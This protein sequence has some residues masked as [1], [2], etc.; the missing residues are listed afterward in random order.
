[1]HVKGGRTVTRRKRRTNFTRK[2]KKKG[3]SKD[4]EKRDITDEYLTSVY[5]DSKGGGAFGGVQNLLDQIHRET[6]VKISRK[7]VEEFL[8]S[9]DEY[10]LHRPA[11]KKFKTEK[12]IVGA[13][14]DYHQM[15]IMVFKAYANQNYGYTYILTVIDCLVDLRGMYQ[16]VR[17]HQRSCNS[18]C[19][20]ISK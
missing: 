14:N 6:R 1:M 13:I 11:V 4:N 16:Y 20:N 15:D 12:V 17:N 8:K 18:T 19:Q 9:R 2:K 7:R 5:T 10:T 3:K